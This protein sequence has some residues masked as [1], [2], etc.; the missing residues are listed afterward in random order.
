MNGAWVQRLYWANT[1]LEGDAEKILCIPLAQEPHDD[2]L[3]WSGESSGKFS[4]RSAYKLL[5][6]Y[7]YNPRAYALQID[8]RNF[9]K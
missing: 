9:Y 4:V 3:V 6:N 1:F 7:G 5:Q 8:Y 2:F